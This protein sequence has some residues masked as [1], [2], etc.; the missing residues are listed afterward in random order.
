MDVLT[1]ET[2]W[3][4]FK[5][6]VNKHDNNNDF[7]ENYDKRGNKIRVDRVAHSFGR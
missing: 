4:I 2:N 5:L 3:Q 7:L 1:I 6:W